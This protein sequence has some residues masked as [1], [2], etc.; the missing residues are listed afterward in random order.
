MHASMSGRFA[1]SFKCELYLRYVRHC[2]VTA[3]RGVDFAACFRIRKL[4][5]AVWDL[6]SE[7]VASPLIVLLLTGLE[8]EPVA[9]SNLVG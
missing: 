8:S 9:T 7:P 3:P 2:A 5:L 4:A 1:V 6:F